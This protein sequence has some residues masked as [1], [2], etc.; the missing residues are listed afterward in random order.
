M[1][2]RFSLRTDLPRSG[3]YYYMQHVLQITAHFRKDGH[4]SERNRSIF[5]HWWSDLDEMVCRKV[6][7]GARI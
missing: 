5:P 3:A 4:F 2:E 1:F 6:R 7:F